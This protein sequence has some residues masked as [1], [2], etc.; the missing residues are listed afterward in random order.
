[1]GRRSACSDDDAMLKCDEINAAGGNVTASALRRACGGKGSLGTHQVHVDNWHKLH[2]ETDEHGVEEM[3]D[4]VVA[5]FRAIWFYLKKESDKG[6][7]FW[8]QQSRA[9]IDAVKQE[10]EELRN[11]ADSLEEEREQLKAEVDSLKAE[12]V[13]LKTRNETLNDVI[14]EARE[15]Q[16]SSA[17]A[18][19]EQA[20][21]NATL[22]GRM[23]QLIDSARAYETQIRER[24]ALLNAVNT[25][26]SA[27]RERHALLTSRESPPKRAA[28]IKTAARKSSKQAA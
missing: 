18:E 26:L 22:R 19:R 16:Q 11:L 23:E 4:E 2:E 10:A 6:L 20:E 13:E 24:D 8:A 17:N 7:K 12:C 14:K 15:A 3:P 5:R 21:E 27:L 25:D 9:S 1:M 28:P